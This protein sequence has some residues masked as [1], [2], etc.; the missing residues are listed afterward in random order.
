MSSLDLKSAYYSVPVAPEHHK[1]LCF[2]WVEGGERKVYAYCCFPN[3][4]TSAPRDFTKL[5][6]PP[7]AFLRLQGVIVAIYIDDTYIQ[8]SN[9]QECREHTYQTFSLLQTLGFTINM[10]K[11][12]FEPSQTLTMLG[13]I[14]DSVEMTVRPTSEKIQKIKTLCTDR[15]EKQKCSI[16]KLAQTI[17]TIISTLPGCKYGSLH[18]RHLEILKSSALKAHK[19]NFEAPV[20]LNP[21]AQEELEW[22][23]QNIDSQYNN[24]DHGK[25]QCLLQTDAS[26]K[27]WGAVYNGTTTGGEWTALEAD[28][29]INYLELLAVFL[30]LRSLCHS[31]QNVH[32]RCQ[33]DNTTAVKYLNAQGG[34]RSVGCNTLA[35][36]IWHWA[37]TRN[38][39]LSASHIAGSLNTEADT[40]SRVFNDRTEWK[41]N[42]E[43][44]LK[45]TTKI[46]TPTIDLFA[47]R[48]NAQLPCY[49]SWQPDPFAKHI[50]AFSIEWSE[51]NSYI[52][53]PFSLINSCLQ[54]LHQD[55]TS[56]AIIIAPIWP[57]QCWF[58]QLMESLINFPLYLPP[59][60]L[61]LPVRSQAKL[62]PNVRLMACHVSGKSCAQRGF[63]RQLRTSSSLVGGQVHKN[64]TSMCLIGGRPIVVKGKLLYLKPLYT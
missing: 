32:I 49:V 22:W 20:M 64:S 38:I 12:V 35:K 7:L 48:L 63:R 47:S 16:R 23:V 10:K 33:I 14:I 39:W 61:S 30:G 41:L 4:L 56:S 37:I 51:T 62:P 15:L 24:I 54:K 27:G 55:S 28:Q 43:V 58:P 21:G 57:S 46:G 50:D 3:G 31:I 17:G 19:G 34:V 9:Y 36:T 52:F 5:M 59:N 26:K 42:E 2:P 6:K 8:G 60:C 18:Y 40:A 11:S 44:F 53:P 45:I 1:Y 25:Y 13:F 29:H